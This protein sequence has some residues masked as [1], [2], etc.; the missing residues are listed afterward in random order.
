MEDN[1]EIYRNNLIY[2]SLIHEGDWRKIYDDLVRR[3]IS[4]PPQ[5]I[6]KA[7]KKL[8]CKALTI[9]DAE[10][11][12]ELR[13]AC[14]PPF[15]LFYYGNINLLNDLSNN[16]GV[17][18]SREYSSYGEKI[19]RNIVKELA[20]HYVI[21]SGMAKGID[22]IAHDQAMRSGGKTI[23]VMCT[24]IDKVYPASSLDIY[25]EMKTNHLVISEYPGKVAPPLEQFPFRNRI[26][27]ALSR[28]LVV[29]E[30]YA[31][32]GTSITASFALQMGKD[33][34]CVPYHADE[35]SF[36]NTLINLGAELIESPEQLIE[37]IEHDRKMK[38]I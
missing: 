26:I 37:D 21:V 17:V 7:L 24:G 14:Q 23:A 20:K 33:V 38:K 6:E 29:T 32:S 4:Y 9:L 22:H 34:Y 36:C 15:V 1:T 19:T 25:N 16:V 31:R 12:T 5:D 35:N 11:P 27:A 18:G 10:Y 13:Q 3:R 30:A 28:C 2:S 8:K